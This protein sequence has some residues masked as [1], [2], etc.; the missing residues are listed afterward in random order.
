MTQSH[1]PLTGIRVVELAGIGPGPHACMM[2]A[3]LGAEVVRIVRPGVSEPPTPYTLRG[4]TTV[5]ADLKDPVDRDR[6]LGLLARADVLV[7]GYRPGVAERLGLGPAEV[8]AANPR[9]VYGRMTGWGQTGPLATSAGHDINYISLTGA[10][11]AIGTAEG[12]V[13]PLN[14]VGDF[15]G[16]SMLLVNGILAALVQR[17]TTGVGQV[18][19]AAMVDGVAVLLAGILELRP[20]G[21][22]TDD[23]ADNILDGAAPYYRTYR[24]AD[25]GFMAAGA[26]E[27]QFYE[28]LVRGL[29]LDPSDLPDRDEKANWAELGERFAAVFATRPRAHWEQVYDGTDACVTPVLSFTEAPSHPQVAARGVLVAGTGDEVVAGAAPVLSA[30]HTRPAG[31]SEVGTLD[32]ALAGWS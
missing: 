29:G 30:G 23:P 27:P 10:L 5:Q 12:P 18:V 16:G 19:D 9:L 28:L 11:H 4:R 7:E 15:G 14:L 2:L 22:W 31:P 26:V 20:L 17:A 24:C 3:D 13:P 1:Q 6:V 21:M 32:E 25:G 8:Q